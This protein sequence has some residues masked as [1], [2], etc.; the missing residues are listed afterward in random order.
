[1]T[2]LKDIEEDRDK[3]ARLLVETQ[4]WT[5][6]ERNTLQSQLDKLTLLHELFAHWIAETLN[7]FKLLTQAALQRDI[8]FA[9]LQIELKKYSPYEGFWQ[10]KLRNLDILRRLLDAW[11]DDSI[12]Q[13]Q[14]K[15]SV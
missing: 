8:D 9:K 6:K 7:E 10:D 13:V 4:D 14:F 3:I 5:Q 11:Q 15:V 1:V 2:P 12:S